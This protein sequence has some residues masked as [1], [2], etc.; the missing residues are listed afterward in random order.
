MTRYSDTRVLGR[1]NWKGVPYFFREKELLRFWL[2][3]EARGNIDERSKLGI[4]ATSFWLNET[5]ITRFWNIFY[6]VIR[7][8]S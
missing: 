2:L 8:Q 4:I 5:H 7:N 6:R 3:Y 1:S